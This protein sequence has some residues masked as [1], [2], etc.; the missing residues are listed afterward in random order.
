MLEMLKHLHLV[1]Q[2]D[3]VHWLNHTNKQNIKKT[4]ARFSVTSELVKFK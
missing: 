1:W 3:L 4:L 2:A